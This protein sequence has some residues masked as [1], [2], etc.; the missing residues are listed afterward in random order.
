LDGSPPPSPL[1]IALIE[2]LSE[3]DVPELSEQHVQHLREFGPLLDQANRFQDFTALMDSGIISRVR[4]L[5]AS[6]GESIYHPLV[7][8]TIAPYNAAFGDHFHAL[9]AAAAG[10]I[11]TFACQLEELG[12]TILTTLDG[13]EITVEHVAALDEKTLLS[14]DYVAALE[15]FHRVSRLK[16]ELER[17]PPVR[18]S[19]PAFAPAA[20][21]V[22]AGGAAAA[23]A[24]EFTYTPPATTPQ[25]LSVEEAKL[26]RVEEAIR[27]FVRVANPKF[28]QIVP[29]R[30][31]NLMLNQAE[32]DAY[33]ADYLDQASPPAD[34]ARLLLRIV[35]LAARITTEMEELKRAPRASAIWK[36]HADLLAVVLGLCKQIPEVVDRLPRTDHNRASVQPSDDPIRISFEKLYARATDAEKLLA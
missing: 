26:R 27:I 22:G 18:R 35:A 11:K 34:T 32:I 36:M 3:S 28:R 24:H 5:K 30:Y 7:L 13:V 23:P 20:H 6:L 8:A 21:V 15:K 29:M 10:K 19:Q 31:F 33:T 2:I 12:G 25:A 1:E 16:K 14:V 4:D 9:F 17:K